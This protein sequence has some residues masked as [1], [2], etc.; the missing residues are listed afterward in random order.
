MRAAL[1]AAVAAVAL[2]LTLPLATNPASAA[3][4]VTVSISEVDLNGPAIS[5]VTVTVTNGTTAKLSKV[6]VAF[7]GPVGWSVYPDSRSVREIRPGQSVSVDFDIRVPEKRPGFTLRTFSATASYNGGSAT[8]TRVQR[9]GEPLPNLAAAYNNVGV[10]DESNP[11]PGNFDGDG[12]SFSAQKLADVG[13]TPG[14]SLSALGATFTWPAAAA[15]TPN[16]VIAGAQAISLSGQGS[17]IAFLGSAAGQ[18]AV[19]TA[20]VW[21]TDGTSSSG[22][23]GFPNW[24]FQDATAHGATLVAAANGRNLPTGYGNAGIDYRIFAHSIT[25]DPAKTVDLV[26]LPSNG[27][28]HIFDLKLVP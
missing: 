21:Y 22:T 13:V 17:K 26:V 6:S 15:G 7:S 10:T 20:T 16:N 19:G 9:S 18:A 5:P 27:S 1:R 8:G 4:D 3:G 11:A 14:A 2:L 23:F 28:I 25:V 12:N 24:S